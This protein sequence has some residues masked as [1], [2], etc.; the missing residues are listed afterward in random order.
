MAAWRASL[1]NNSL[2]HM[3]R[4]RAGLYAGLFGSVE[5]LL[6]SQEL[7]ITAAPKLNPLAFDLALTPA[8]RHEYLERLGELD[9]LNQFITGTGAQFLE[10]ASAAG[11]EFRLK[12]SIANEVLAGLPKGCAARSTPYVKL[13]PG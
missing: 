2:A 5:R 10:H 12:K 9:D 11:P 7:E 3:P 1:T 13:A 6:A 4:A 8:E